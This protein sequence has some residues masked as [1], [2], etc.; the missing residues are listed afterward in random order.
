LPYRI[1]IAAP[2]A[3]ALDLL[4]EWGALD[5]EAV[6]DGLA[7][8]LPDGVARETVARALGAVTV[9]EAVGRDAGSVWLLRPREVRV[10]G[11]PLV[12][13]DSTAFGTGQHPTTALCLEAL[14]ESVAAERP[15]SILD[16]G[17]GSGILALAALRLGVPRAVGVDLDA[18]A[19][20]AAAENARRNGLADRLTLVRGGPEAVEGQWPLLAANVLAA[21][22]I[23]M[24]PALVRRLA[25]GGRLL[26]SGIPRSLE[27]EV[28]L[29]YRHLGVRQIASRT[30]AGWTLL[31]ALAPW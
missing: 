14:E 27:A 1:D 3:E 22:L 7:A 26:L 10:A 8:I 23:E 11:A 21:P 13:A 20:E 12:L 2:P 9:S 31:T 30:R 25:G 6:E 19:I 29:A 15:E 5:V 18:G 24:A 4:L 17:T 28:A 16:V